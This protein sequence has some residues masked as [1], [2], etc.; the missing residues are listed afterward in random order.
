MKSGRGWEDDKID[1]RLN[2]EKKEFA[3]YYADIKVK[4]EDF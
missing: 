2:W 3:S 4:N 1:T